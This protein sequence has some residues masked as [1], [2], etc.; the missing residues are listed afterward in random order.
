[1]ARQERVAFMLLKARQ[2][3]LQG[4]LDI[5]DS[6]DRNRMSPPDMRRVLVDLKDRGLVRVKLRPGEIGS[7]LQQ[8]VAVQNSVIAGGISG[9]RGRESYREPRLEPLC[10]A[11]RLS[12][13]A[14]PHEREY[15]RMCGAWKRGL[16]LSHTKAPLRH[17]EPKGAE[18]RH[19]QP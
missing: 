8:R 14:A 16:W 12:L 11:H 9:W 17:R 1:M 7:E 19:A 15:P 2:Q 6:A 4:R 5:A 10:C 18:N 13:G 3:G